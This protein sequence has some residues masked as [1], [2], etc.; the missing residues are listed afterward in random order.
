V[1]SLPGW[2]VFF[3]DLTTDVKESN[4]KTYRFSEDGEAGF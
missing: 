4:K 1:S 3:K 2:S